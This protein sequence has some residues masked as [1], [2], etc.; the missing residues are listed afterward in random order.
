MVD[1]GRMDDHTRVVLRE[2][3]Q[4]AEWGMTQGD[5]EGEA[6][7]LQLRE[8]GSA[9]AA[10]LEHDQDSESWAHRAVA[11]LAEHCQRA[12]STW[13]AG[14]IATLARLRDAAVTA[15][16]PGPGQADRQS[17]R[18]R[19]APA[20]VR[21]AL[22]RGRRAAAVGLAAVGCAVLAGIAIAGTGHGHSSAPKASAT[23]LVSVPAGLSGTAGT[24]TASSSPVLTSAT[25]ST[26]VTSSTP[27]TSAAPGS[28]PS[29]THVTGIQMTAAPADGY[30]EVQVYGTITASGT[31]DVTITVTVA[32]TSGHPQTTTEDESGQRSYALS[33]T[34]YL[35]PW[36]G[37]K[38]VTIT[39]S[40][41]SVSQ[42]AAVPISGC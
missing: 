17:A 6:N 30:P 4:R 1:D 3:A 18:A 20:A 33:Q 14:D 2:L 19:R 12:A 10:R 15:L 25:S 36:C 8:L 7:A 23:T 39:V 34:L 21:L 16:A 40:S 13:S 31:G 22:P 37:Q 5:G 27:A 29:T 42:S 35:N 32:G 9:I 38:S 24:T 28:P 26:P 11:E 41:G